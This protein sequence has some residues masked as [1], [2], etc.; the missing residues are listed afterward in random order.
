MTMKVWEQRSW[1]ALV[2]S[3]IA[4]TG[5]HPG[6]ALYWSVMALLCWVLSMRLERDP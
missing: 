5:H 1:L 2:I 3:S 4:Y 6:I